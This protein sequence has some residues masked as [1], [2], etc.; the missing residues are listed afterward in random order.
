[1]KKLYFV[2]FLMSL[3]FLWVSPSFSE[4]SIKDAEKPAGLEV[5]NREGK[6]VGVARRIEG[7]LVFFDSEAV[8]FKKR[9]NNE[10]AIYNAR[11]QHVGKLTRRKDHL[12]LTDNNGRFTGLSL[13]IKERPQALGVNAKSTTSSL[14]DEF[15]FISTVTKSLKIEHEAAV[16]YYNV[17]KALE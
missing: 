14:K 17:M 4:R 13:S 9:N 8:T 2:I 3:S 6:S 10:W 11:D 1:M 5:Y 16:L 7:K 15:E 12:L